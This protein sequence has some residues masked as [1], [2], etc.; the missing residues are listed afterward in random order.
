MGGAQ[1]KLHGSAR[2]GGLR[3]VPNWSSM[4][5]RAMSVGL[6]GWE[7][8]LYARAVKGLPL[9]LPPP[10]VLAGPGGDFEPILDSPEPILERLRKAPARLSSSD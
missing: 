5:P 9:P 2:P 8:T 10:S 6:G 3:V 4:G 1:L 7:Y